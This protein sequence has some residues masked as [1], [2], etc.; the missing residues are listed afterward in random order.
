MT[1]ASENFVMSAAPMRIGRVTLKVRDL[2]KVSDFYRDTIGLS[3]LAKEDRRAIL[4]TDGAP[5]LVLDGDADLAPSDRRQAGL[6]H[7]AFLLPTRAD[8]ARWL[9][10]VADARTPLQGASDDIVSEAIYLGD[11]E[12]NGIEV[13]VD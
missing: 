13:Y 11:P 7:T 5:L 4:G 9:R 3:V 12:G 10:H 6:F 1:N 8:L 2:D